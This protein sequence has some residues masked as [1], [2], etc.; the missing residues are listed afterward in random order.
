[1]NLLYIIL[2]AQTEDTILFLIFGL[3]ISLLILFYF[4]RYTLRID[5]LIKNQKEIIRLLK[6]NV[7]EE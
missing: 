1:M 7:G 3:A 4:L 2:D 5:Q 6:K